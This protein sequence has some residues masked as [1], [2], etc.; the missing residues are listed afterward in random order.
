MYSDAE[1]DEYS[2]YMEHNRQVIRQHE[3]PK[4]VLKNMLDGKTLHKV[5]DTV[6]EI[7]NGGFTVTLQPFDLWLLQV[8]RQK[9][10]DQLLK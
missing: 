8:T 3:L 5:S 4:K 7:R 2:T 9:K 10:I 6:W 1:L